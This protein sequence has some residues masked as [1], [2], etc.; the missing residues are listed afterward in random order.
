MKK[1]YY[2]D[3]PEIENID[4]ILDR[5]N[6][7]FNVEMLQVFIDYL[8]AV[9]DKAAWLNELYQ[10]MDA[11]PELTRVIMV[12]I[13]PK[14]QNNHPELLKIPRVVQMSSLPFVKVNALSETSLNV[15]LG[16]VDKL[17]KSLTMQ[18]LM[19]YP[20]KAAM[21]VPR[22]Q[23]FNDVELNDVLIPFC[24]E[25]SVLEHAFAN[26]QIKYTQYGDDTSTIDYLVERI[27]E[28][29]ELAMKV[30]NQR[31]INRLFELGA[32]NYHYGR[33]V[34]V[35][36]KDKYM[37]LI[38]TILCHRPDLY[39]G[40]WLIS[41]EQRIRNLLL[42]MQQPKDLPSYLTLNNIQ[43]GMVRD[44]DWMEYILQ[45]W[46]GQWDTLNQIITS[47]RV[48]DNVIRI[49][50]KAMQYK[51]SHDI[52]NKMEA[53]YGVC[54]FKK[55]CSL[56]SLLDASTSKIKTRHNEKERKAAGILGTKRL[57]QLKT[58]QEQNGPI[59]DT[60]K[61]YVE[62]TVHAMQGKQKEFT[63]Q[64]SIENALLENEMEILF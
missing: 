64:A 24:G 26:A 27:K 58:F 14:F 16:Q 9:D 46:I 50:S 41:P 23:S 21:L 32:R 33:N 4:N 8:N 43:L 55:T 30:V 63:E 3:P 11:Y 6:S 60:W 62:L 25:E 5:L 42:V 17:D 59:G 2:L 1:F 31:H 49:F 38:N 20:E 22:L 10:A 45:R 15:I 53:T 44:E 57:N 54:V 19:A 34:A 12:D 48:S 61:A 47:G 7:Y 28:N 40:L 37:Q 39:Y 56:N 35:F 52:L 18:L 13:V 51:N 36:K 29:K